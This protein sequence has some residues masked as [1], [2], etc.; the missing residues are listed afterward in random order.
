MKYVS[1]MIALVFVVIGSASHTNAQVVDKTKDAAEKAAKVTTDTAKKTSVVV[2][3]T[4]G[5][6]AS[7]TKSA[8]ESAV[9][10]T[11]TKAQTFGKN[12]VNVTE[13]VAGQTYEGGKYLTVTSWD[14][15]KWV[16]KQVWYPNSKTSAKP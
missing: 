16:S 9:K 7:K 10:T 3:D 2:T 14:G 6:A 11:T 4:L 12:S 13:S 8:T 1:L 15:A 5:D